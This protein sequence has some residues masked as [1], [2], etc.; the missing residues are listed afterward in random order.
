MKPLVIAYGNTLRGDDGAGPT[1]AG[2]LNQTGALDVIV[3]HQLTPELAEPISRASGVFFVDAQA[4]LPAGQL[5]VKPLHP[6]KCE[7]IHGSSPGRLLEWS[8]TLYTRSPEAILI[9]IGGENYE[10]GEGLTPA[11]QDAARKA[12][13]LIEDSLNCPASHQQA[14]DEEDQED[15]KKDLR[16]TCRCRGDAAKAQDGCQDCDH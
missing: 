8:R 14:D 4:D 16:D 11:V 12:C 5:A 10:L 9:G 2:F 13:R 1:V 7:R 15:H 3:V 6:E